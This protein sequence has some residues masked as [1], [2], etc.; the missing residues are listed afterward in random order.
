MVILQMSNEECRQMLVS[1]RLAR[2]GCSYQDQPY[3]VPVYLGYDS[4]DHCFYGFTTPGQKIEWMR[5]NPRV[6][7]EIDEVIATDQWTSVVVTGAFEELAEIGSDNQDGSSI[8]QRT[9]SAGC[10]EPV[11]SASYVEDENKRERA[12]EVL[13]SHPEWWEPGC[14]VWQCR[15]DRSSSERY[16]PVYYRIQIDRLTG[17]KALPAS[18]SD[19]V[20]VA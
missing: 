7:V 11:R 1:T 5:L 14:S 4:I 20:P 2:L 18:D 3:I 17:R 19:S 13:Q 6:C 15:T 12:W 10:N 8:L 16:S 9:Y